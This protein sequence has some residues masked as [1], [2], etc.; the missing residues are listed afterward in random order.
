MNL[1]PISLL[2]LVLGGC[3][4]SPGY[5]VEEYQEIKFEDL[6]EDIKIPAK[7]WDA[8]EFKSAGGHE[9]AAPSAGGEHGAPAGG[10]HSST[11]NLLF[12]EVTVFLVQK[13]P[14]IVEGEAVKILLPKG[15]GTIDLSRF[16]TGQRGSFYVGFEFPAF[17]KATAKKVLFVSGTRKRRIE[18]K[19]FGAGCNQF[20][21]ITD[22][23][24]KE[25]KGEGLKVNTTQ[26]RYLSVLGGTFLFSAQQG[27]DIHVA[28]V[29]FKN[30]QYTPLF[31]EVP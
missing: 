13:N 11:K 17:E 25:M 29:T 14:G 15:G 18:Q 30:S 9:E 7:A 4:G 8:L 24:M 23:F 5:H 21:D 12:S 3:T 6:A 20:F 19:I 16:I 28:Q 26:E 1:L 10:E 22:R 2:L 31:C 27:S